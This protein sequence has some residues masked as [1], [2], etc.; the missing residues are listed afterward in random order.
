MIC[1]GTKGRLANKSWTPGTVRRI[2]TELKQKLQAQQT[3]A[4]RKEEPPSNN[5]D[6]DGMLQNLSMQV[7]VGYCIM[8]PN[9]NLN[10][11]S[12]G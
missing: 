11:S 4:V 9:V 12:C 3:S 1:T 6:L 8:S 5:D 10:L 7:C 2:S